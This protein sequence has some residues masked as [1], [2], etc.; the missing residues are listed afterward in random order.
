MTNLN[1]IYDYQRLNSNHLHHPLHQQQQQNFRNNNSN[2]GAH[3]HPQQQQ[4]QHRTSHHQHHFA[5]NDDLDNEF[6]SD[7]D[8]DDNNDDHILNKIIGNGGGGSIHANATQINDIYNRSC[9][10]PTKGWDVFV[11]TP[12]EDEDETLSSKWIEKILKFLKLI[13]FLLTFLIVLF[14]A[15]F[16]KSVVLFMTSM[17]RSNRTVPVCAQGIPGLER[18]KKYVAV[19]QPDDPERIAWIW[20]L[21]FILVFPEFMTLFRSVRI[22]TFKSYR[23][24]T[25]SI[26]FT[27]SFI[28]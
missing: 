26:F 17:I 24:P 15:V 9:I 11:D 5:N 2:Y 3:F 1:D 16:S 21:F 20:S 10:E 8:A 12:P 22:C 13:T 23:I 6:I 28:F 18:D 19:Y 4:Q 25:K 27:V 7:N 14:T